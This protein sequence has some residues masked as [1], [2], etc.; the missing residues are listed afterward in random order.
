MRARNIKPG[1]YKNADLVECSISA[2]Y[3]A[4]GLWMMAD[5]EGRL[6]DR[7]RQIKIEI[8]P[9]DDVDV[10]QLLDELAAHQHIQRYEIGGKR[11]I[12]ICK[13]KEHQ[14]PHSN[15]TDS[16]IPDPNGE[17]SDTK[18]K[19]LSAKVESASPKSKSTSS[20]TTDSY[21]LNPDPITLP[22]EGGASIDSPAVDFKK[23]FFTEGLRMIGE[24]TKGN[25][26]LIG[27]W[28]RDYG[29]NAVGAAFMA[30]QK[31]SAFDPKTYIIKTLREN[32]NATNFKYHAKPTFKSEK[33]GLTAKYLADAERE[34]QSAVSGGSGANL[35]LAESV[36]E[37]PG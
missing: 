24:D 29:E 11:F 31:Q 27:Q 1:F 13:F 2:R 23:V 21:L 12:Q 14:R 37:N 9:C 8:F 7:P 6:E 10:N 30:A 33:Q 5:K 32:K 3:L 36:R 4:P 18:Q 25:R 28:L 15:E 22:T 20:L 26:S 19:I 17:I 35:Y 34:E 16:V